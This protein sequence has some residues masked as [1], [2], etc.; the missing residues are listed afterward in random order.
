MHSN[1]FLCQ[2]DDLLCRTDDQLKVTVHFFKG[3][4]T[5]AWWWIHLLA[6]DCSVDHFW[7]HC[8]VHTN[9]YS[10]CCPHANNHKSPGGKCLLY[11]L[12]PSLF[13]AYGMNLDSFWDVCLAC[14][15]ESA[16]GREWKTIFLGN[17]AEPCDVA[18]PGGPARNRPGEG[19][20][21]SRVLH[22]LQH[23]RQ[24][25]QNA[26]TVGLH[27]HLLPRVPLP[28]YDHLHGPPKL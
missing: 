4:H 1:K 11:K 3:N 15:S 19:E 17:G 21:S 13:W 10:Q 6:W 18:H 25:L 22:L 27:S 12:C 14:S 24:R 2:T 20:L 5:K 8:N 23:L 9:V 7:L 28:Y 16:Q 26:K